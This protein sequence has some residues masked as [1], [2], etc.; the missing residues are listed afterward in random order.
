[1]VVDDLQDEDEFEV[2]PPKFFQIFITFYK[3]LS[4][5]RTVIWLMGVWG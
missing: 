3:Y 1:M 4:K 5:K 2:G